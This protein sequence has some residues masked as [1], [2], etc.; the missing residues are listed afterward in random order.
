M[1][2]LEEWR[3]ERAELN[4]SGDLAEARESSATAKR[5]LIQELAAEM[6]ETL[7]LSKLIEE[8]NKPK[9]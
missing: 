7:R 1:T 3:N 5:V 9:T 6:T 2:T 8:A 4:L